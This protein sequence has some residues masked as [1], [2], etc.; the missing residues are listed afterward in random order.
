[1]R[2]ATVAIAVAL[3]ATLTAAGPAK[4][5]SV[6]IGAEG[7]NHNTRSAAFEEGGRFTAVNASLHV[8]IVTAYRG[9]WPPQ[10]TPALQVLG[11]PDWLG[12][13][14]FTIAALAPAG[15]SRPAMQEMLKTLLADRFGLK[16][17]HDVHQLPMY[18]LVMARKDRR[19]GGKL[20]PTAGPCV[21]TPAT[22]PPDP[23]GLPRC[24]DRFGAS[25]LHGRRLSLVGMSMD[26]FAASLSGVNFVGG[27]VFNSTGLEGIFDVDLEF[28]T[29]VKEPAAFFNADAADAAAAD[30]D[31]RLSIFDAITDQLGLKL[32]AVKKGPVEVVVIDRADGPTVD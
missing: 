8:L 17:R 23:N 26:Q 28:T 5:Q 16:V 30:T 1:V 29:G 27:P 13:E 7:V 14:G 15:S 6:A 19:V 4:F 3:A 21:N 12:T 32:E 2:I 11:G 25:R 9:V 10:E 18:R 20:Q 24:S 22:A 31:T